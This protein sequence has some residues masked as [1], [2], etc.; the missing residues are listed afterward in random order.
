MA[1][2]RMLIGVEILRLIEKLD[3][4]KAKLNDCLKN[5]SR[6]DNN[7]IYNF[8][9]R[10]D[11]LY[12]DVISNFKD[13]DEEVFLRNPFNE[14]LGIIEHNIQ[15]LEDN[16]DFLLKE[17]DV[18]GKYIITESYNSPVFNTIESFLNNIFGV[19][20][21]VKFRS[22]IE[23]AIVKFNKNSSKLN[24]K[25]SNIET[26]LDDLKN[27]DVHNIFK[28]DSD[29]F[30]K[31]ARIYEAAFYITLFFMFSYFSGW[32]IDINTK[33]LKFKMAE[34]FYGNQTPT[35]YI[36]KVSILILS[37]TLAAFLLKRSFMNRRLADEAYR[38][39]KELDALPRYM[40]GMSPELKEKIRFDL[41]YKYFGNGI[42]PDSYTSGENLMHEN[43]KANTD[44]FK[45]VNDLK[46]P[47]VS[48]S[49]T[50]G[51]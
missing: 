19:L 44:F 11:K 25:V 45:V 5:M 35:F 14:D 31:I 1:N 47:G 40:S 13:L 22:D 21:S 24:E 12:S 36:Q 48:K 34:Q 26:S 41:A 32:F 10:I 18:Q 7:D 17:K 20:H 51:K 27:I 33:F 15:I 16:I 3:Q 46:N 39:S 6:L 49:E 43:I 29:K 2:E 28:N 42:H 30:I 50:E 4:Q 37:T 23:N 38:T 8:F 9:I